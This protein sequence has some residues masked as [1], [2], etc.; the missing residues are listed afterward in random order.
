MKN[1]NKIIL[2]VL[3]IFLVLKLIIELDGNISLRYLSDDLARIYKF[4]DQLPITINYIIFFIA[5]LIATTKSFFSVENYSLIEHLKIN[6]LIYLSTLFPSLLFLRILD[7]ER[8]YLLIFVIIFPLFDYFVFEYLNINFN[9]VKIGILIVV[10]VS[11]FLFF[12]DGDIDIAEEDV[13]SINIESF[14]LGNPTKLISTFDISN[15]YQI[16]KFR[17]CCKEFNYYE[18]SGKS[19]G[20][21]EIVGDKLL[22]VNGFGVFNLYKIDDFYNKT[23]QIPDLIDSNLID[24]IKNNF[25]FDL[26]SW[27]SIKDLVLINGDIYISY[28]EENETDC[29]N[30]EVLKAKFNDKFLEFSTF[31]SYPECVNRNISPYNAHQSGG[32]L[33]N[34]NNDNLVLTIGDFRKYTKPQ[35]LNSFFGKIIKIDLANQEFQIV[36]YGHRNPQGL[37]KTKNL[38]YLVST[39]HGPRGGDE[40][41]IINIKQSE[42]FGWPV[43]SYGEHYD[44]GFIESAPLYKSH[45]DYGFKEPAW[46][47]SHHQNDVH[48]ISDIVPNNFSE[49]DSYFVGSMK[50]TLLYEVTLDLVNNTLLSHE[51]YKVGERIRDIQYYSPLDLYFLLLEESPSI[52]V[53]TQK[54]DFNLYK[55][56]NIS[57]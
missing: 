26:N 2:N 7:I 32:K 48:G 4:E 18:L 46:F 20:Y 19:T 43:A 57:E 55:P 8:L 41:N 34:L 40:I 36:S 27:E 9:L 51:T 28:L 49:N 37:T 16:D 44:G 38:D 50:A 22:H 25:V 31:F 1:K 45:S 23:S 39:E 14:Y 54:E 42:N 29:V 52:A 13:E 30:V 12:Q 6:Y 56:I 11:V 17:I 53:L 3:T 15:K 24:V 10:T 5:T 33:L 47:Y 21:L 35:D